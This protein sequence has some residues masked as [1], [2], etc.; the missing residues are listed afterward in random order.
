MNTNRGASCAAPAEPRGGADRLQDQT[1]NVGC[2]ANGRSTPK[3][4]ANSSP[5]TQSPPKMNRASFNEPA[6]AALS[7]EPTLQ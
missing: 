4:D 7:V 3:A 5:A 2:L 1:A 6:E